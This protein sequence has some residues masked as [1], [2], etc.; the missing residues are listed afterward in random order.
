MSDVHHKQYSTRFL[1]LETYTPEDY[2]CNFLI[3]ASQLHLSP[4]SN[5]L[6]HTARRLKAG[7]N[8]GGKK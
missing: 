5:P 8:P 3:Q 7:A 1:F 6:L 2:L 4:G